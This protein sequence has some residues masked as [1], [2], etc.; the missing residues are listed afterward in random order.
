MRKISWSAVLLTLIVLTI[1]Q[2]GKAE[3]YTYDAA[4]RLTGVT[5][6]D[7]SIITY[8]YDANGNRMGR[9]VSAADVVPPVI[10]LLGANPLTVVQGTTF[11]DPG[12]TV[13]DNVDTGLTATVTGVVNTAVP[14]T[15][16]LT[17]NAVD[18]AG[19]AATPVTRTVEVVASTVTT[20]PAPVSGGG[21]CVI[22]PATDFDPVFVLMLLGALAVLCRKP[23][24]GA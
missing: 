7:G 3:N 20:T 19:N 6:D 16:I 24:R 17:Y 23:G 14:G 22:R 9:S 5:Y 4:G 1:V 11:I 12:V 13:T 21:G 8:S 15:Y 10:T 18:T 2:P